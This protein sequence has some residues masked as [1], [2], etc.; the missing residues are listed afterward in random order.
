MRDEQLQESLLQDQNDEDE[1]ELL[2]NLYTVRAREKEREEIYSRMYDKIMNIPHEEKNTY[3]VEELI[4]ACRR[5]DYRLVI[6]IV[7]QKFFTIGPNQKDKQSGMTA[8]Y[9]TLMHVLTKGTTDLSTLSGGRGGSRLMK[10]L[11]VL[12][13]TKKEQG[14]NMEYVIKVLLDQGGD[15]NYVWKEKGEDGLT[16][17]HRAAETGNTEFVRWLLTKGAGGLTLSSRDKKSPLAHAAGGGHVECALMLLDKGNA[18]KGINHVDYYGCTAL[19]YC[20]RGGVVNMAMV[21]LYCGALQTVRNKDGKLASDEARG[22]GHMD[23]VAAMSGYHDP[24]LE[25]T[26]RMQ[27]M[28]LFY[29]KPAEENA[30]QL[31]EVDTPGDKGSIFSSEFTPTRLRN[32][33]FSLTNHENNV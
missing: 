16:L 19:H 14:S 8:T 23:M 22:N 25:R 28:S 26:I 18:I 17:M 11:A 33:V 30:D 5:G 2:D 24:T 12:R 1:Q 7:T 32:Q 9:A 13:R 6:D 4:T 29:P 10:V 27:F 20:A 31:G 21:L 3:T 15:V